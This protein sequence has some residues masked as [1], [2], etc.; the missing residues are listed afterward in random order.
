VSLVLG[1]ATVPSNSTVQVFI[2][3]P[4]TVN[5]TFWQ[6]APAATTVYVG[7]S[8]RLSSVNGL[9][10]NSTPVN[11]ESYVTSAGTPVFATTGGNTAA[12]FMYIISGGS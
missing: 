1:Q 2:L 3:P 4:G 5:T 12:S 11:V 7:S 10:L 8:V 6:P 9:M